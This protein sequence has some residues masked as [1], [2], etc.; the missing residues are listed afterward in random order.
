MSAA[1]AAEPVSEPVSGPAAGSP[2]TV[3]VEE[4]FLLVDAATRRPV[5]AVEAV[6]A[7]TPDGLPGHV[8][9]EFVSNQIEIGSR[10]ATDLATLR[11]SLAALRVAVSGAARRAGAALVPIGCGPFDAPEPSVADEPRYRR[12]AAEFG[13]VAAGPGLNGVHVHVGIAD[14]E[15]GVRVL[16]HLR[17]W[18]PVLHAVTANSPFH[19]GRDTGY[20][21]WRSVLWARWPTVGPTPHLRSATHYEDLVAELVESGAMLDRG[22]LYWYSRLSSHVPTVEVR[23]GDVCPT[24]DDTVFL[25]A[26]VRALVGT[27]LEAVASGEPPPPVPHTVLVAA[28]WRAAR[29]G[30]EG[31]A[32][33]PADRALRPAWEVLQRLF[34]LVR[35]QLERHGDATLAADLLDGLRR[36]GTGAARQRAVF[37]RRRDLADVVD[38]LAGQVDPV[39]QVAPRRGTG[40][41]V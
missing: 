9:R 36:H 38:Y 39:G 29:D 37:A 14:A 3:G 19:R 18:L 30:L 28:H 2:L 17:P 8:T 27:A 40:P 6:I 7:A 16:N 25:A 15:S 35:P 13:A 20:A 31:M 33:D 24:L 10:P 22:M 23:V 12:M 5:P 32:V 41:G 26:M 21:S 4:E 34:A 1:P 11:E